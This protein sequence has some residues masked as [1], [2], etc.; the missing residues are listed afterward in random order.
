MALLWFADISTKPLLF[1]R[2]FVYILDKLQGRK[3]L[4]EA[5][6]KFEYPFEI[7][8]S[9]LAVSKS[10]SKPLIPEISTKPGQF[11][12]RI[13][14]SWPQ[15]PQRCPWETARSTLP[16][17]SS[18]LSQFRMWYP[19]Q[20]NGSDLLNQPWFADILATA[21]PFFTRNCVARLPRFTSDEVQRWQV[22]KSFICTGTRCKFWIS[23]ER[24]WHVVYFS[25]TTRHSKLES[26][27]LYFK[28]TNWL[29]CRIG[30]ICD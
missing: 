6:L 14:A 20:V 22:Q 28:G 7:W 19:A 13:G 4:W 23:Q 17:R 10:R 5:T 1:S 16:I 11:R 15:S 18:L 3:S 8:V 30:S 2:E 29:V 27:F 12:V 21:G 26:F 24:K 9:C 25:I